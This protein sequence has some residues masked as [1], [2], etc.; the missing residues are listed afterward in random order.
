MDI[1]PASVS[2]DIASNVSMQAFDGVRRSRMR[3]VLRT[4]FL[5]LACLAL[6]YTLKGVLLTGGI[7]FLCAL[8]LI[9]SYYWN[10]RDQV[11]LAADWMLWTLTIALG[12]LALL[13]QGLRDTALMGYPGLLVFA[14][15]LWRDRTLLGLIVGQVTI[16]FVIWSLNASGIIVSKIDS[17]GS[18]QILDIAAV[19]G[20]T[21]FAAWLI[22]ADQRNYLKALTQEHAVAT[23]TLQQLEHSIRH[24]TLTSLP[25]RRAAT[26]ALQVLCDHTVLNTP[27]TAVLLINLDHFKSIN[28]S[29]GPAVGDEYLVHLCERMVSIL[30]PGERLYRVGSD[31]FLLLRHQSDVSDTA[32]ARSHEWIRAIAQPINLSGVDISITAS[33]G[34]VIFPVDGNTPKELLMR[35][36]TAMQGAKDAG[37]NSVNRYDG[38]NSLG[39][40]SDHLRMLADMRKALLS[41]EFFLH[42]QPKF[43][44]TTSDLCGAEVLLRW[45]HPV[46]GFVSPATFIPLAE[47][48]GFIV[49]L[50][51]WVLQETC[52]QIGRWRA[53]GL[54]VPPI[55]INVSMVQ[56][57]RG[58]LRDLVYRSLQE[59]DIPGSALELEL[60][61]S[62]LSDSMAVVQS[63]LDQLRRLGV[64]LAIDDFGTGYSNLGYLK[65]FEIQTLKIDQSFVR[66]VCTSPPDQAIVRAIVNMATQ[67]DLTTVAEG[68]ETDEVAQTLKNLG[69][70]MGQGYLWSQ[71]LPATEFETKYLLQPKLA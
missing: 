30:G 5:V 60:T 49:E 20:L 59:A 7:L 62:L 8:A 52:R 56:F 48:S 25:N 13:N 64:T 12:C 22:A 14:I 39:Q 28:E 40:T 23:T 45:R 63:T 18:M 33:A 44:L 31:E 3:R 29:L 54:Q 17:A 36:D 35:A 19:V 10:Q 34:L 38:G 61:E 1:G 43:Q 27:A 37:R 21:A 71:A 57:R 41:G 58:N 69:C 4:V 6:T 42:F 70:E 67:L 9:P 24:D 15:L 68:I 46:L 55:A 65:Q 53:C 47:K 66:K 51:S 32:V 11:H 16:A 50:G 26:E 2:E